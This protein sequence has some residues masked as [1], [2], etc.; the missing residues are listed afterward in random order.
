MLIKQMRCA[1]KQ[2]DS[3]AGSY[4]GIPNMGGT[5]KVQ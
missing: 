2:R 4:N 5:A 1:A 3:R